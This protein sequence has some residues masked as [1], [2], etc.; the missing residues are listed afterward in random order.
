MAST[1]GSQPSPS[2]PRRRVL[3]VDDNI[4]L[5]TMTGALLRSLG[6]EVSLAHD[7]PDALRAIEVAHPEVAFVDIGLPGMSGHEVAQ[8][9]RRR[10]GGGELLL[11]AMT[12][13]GQAEDRRR[14][15]DAGFDLHLVKPVGLQA[16]QNVLD[17]KPIRQPQ[18]A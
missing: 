17:S 6:H 14:S 10:P 13:Y 7:G 16:L 8:A 4:D 11:V 1:N 12:G 2:S 5:A 3:L 9:I 15:R 18:S